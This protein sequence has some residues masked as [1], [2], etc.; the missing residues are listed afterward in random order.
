[1]NDI[2]QFPTSKKADELVALCGDCGCTT[3]FVNCTM[4]INDKPVLECAN[5]AKISDHSLEIEWVNKTYPTPAEP[6]TRDDGGSIRTIALGSPERARRSVVKKVN[7]WNTAETLA[8]VIGYDNEGRGK[9]WLD[10]STEE[11]KT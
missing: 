11:Q 7:E 9:Q 1:M 3:F 6:P 2:I 10:I 4:S 8:I 5:C